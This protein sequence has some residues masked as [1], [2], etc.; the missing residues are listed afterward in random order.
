MTQT[1][2]L[3]LFQP[4]TAADL[5]AVEA[6][7]AERVAPVF[8]EVSP[9]ADAGLPALLTARGYRPFEFSSVLYRPIDQAGLKARTTPEDA[10]LKPRATGDGSNVAT[11]RICSRRGT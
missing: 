3:G 6:F 2:G 7:C 5:D 10:G 8:R 1:F 11:A 9:L 4:V